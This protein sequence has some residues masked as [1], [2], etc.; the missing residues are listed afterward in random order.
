MQMY[1]H[2]IFVELINNTKDVLYQKNI[3]LPETSDK[4]AVYIDNRINE[5]TKYAIYNHMYFLD[6]KFTLYFFHSKENEEYIKNELKDLKNIKYIE[7]DVPVNNAQ[8]HTNF[9]LSPFIYER[10]LEDHILTFQSDSMM[11]KHWDDKFNE[12][13]CIGSPWLAQQTKTGGNQGIGLRS[14]T[15]MLKVLEHL[16][17][18][19]KNLQLDGQ[20]EDWIISMAAYY[21]NMKVNGL[22]DGME[23]GC[24]TIFSEKPMCIHQIHNFQT[25]ENVKLILNNLKYD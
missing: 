21:F 7:F 3:I 24:E 2:P 5:H 18:L 15:L 13:C 10:V 17:F 16:T 20:N 14:R 22:E 6:G 4:A 11:L 25:E 12:Y 23:F 19:K 1:D 9:M 8:E